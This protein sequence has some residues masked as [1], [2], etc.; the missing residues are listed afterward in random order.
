MR[1][2]LA[3]ALV[4]FWFGAFPVWC[5]QSPFMSEQVYRALVN[6]ISGDIAFEHIRWF[7]HYHKS[8]GSEGFEA[9]ARYAEQKAKEYGLEDVRF[10]K[11]PFEGQSWTQKLGELW[12]LEPERRR[13]AFTPEVALSLAD[14]SR[15]TDIKSVDLVDVGDGVADSDFTGKQVAG[16]VVLAS[17]PVARVMEAAVWKR[18]ALGVVSFTMVARRIHD[19]PD[20]VQWI[21]IPIESS[22]KT[23]KG[24]FAFVLSN[25]EGMRLRRDMAAAKDKAF[26][27]RARIESVFADQ[28]WQA[29][30]EG[31]IRGT[32]IH[33]QDIV[34]TG[35]LQEERFSANDDGSG[36]GNGLEIGRALKKMIDEGT[37]PRPRRDIR[38]WWVNENRSEEQYFADFPE[39]RRQILADINQDMSGAKLSVQSRVQFVTRPP[40]SRASFLGDIVES[41]IE[42]LVQGNTAYL[43]AHAASVMKQPNADL[44]DL[45]PGRQIYSRLGTRE[46]YD[47][48]IIPFHNSTDSQVFNM[49][50][51]GIP[52]VTFTDW[53]D[54]N[55][56]ST[57]DDMW[58]VDP[59][60]LKRNAVAVAAMVW[61]LANAADAQVP[62]LA[63]HMY[64][65]A[66]S[67]MGRDMRIAMGM[68]EEAVPGARQ[69][70]YASALSIVRQGLKRERQALESVR[71]FLT[72]GGTGGRVLTSTLAQ[73]PSE[74]ELETKLAA[75]YTGLTGEKAP[76]P[77][78]SARERE[79]AVKVPTAVDSV[80]AFL[81]G[82]S[83]LET[84]ATLH[85]LMAYEA[86]NFVNGKNSYLDIYQA[87]AAEAAAGG[88]WYYGTVK[89]EDI[90]RYLDSAQ[91]AGMIRVTSL[92]SPAAK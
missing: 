24:T 38:F 17:G 71:V 7:T 53:P 80:K 63:G 49:G 42:T 26:K 84:P 56:H 23:Q 79:L 5:Q 78:L 45:H 30:V 20:Q 19:F 32:E 47:A 69:P 51:I 57:D 2:S 11:Q 85:G 66:V 75:F 82:R 43:S 64:G 60:Q 33:D 73:L 50:I 70:A 21:R 16:K 67:R 36:V 65:N 83:K 4:L 31:L 68:I 52:A 9:V 40:F 54:E 89:M 81:A 6:E 37:L 1:K 59:T 77:S 12:L 14:Y 61:Y 18:G 8:T 44:E 22:D 15:P 29:I 35:H 13:L 28:P 91:K 76:Q 86:L 34:L 58:Q 46:Q 74:S 41:I 90:A 72:T 92:T 55:I 88:D 39:E 48:R 25:R 62:A 3:A 27:V 87:V 10:I